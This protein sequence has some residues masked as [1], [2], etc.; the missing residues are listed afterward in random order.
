M[1][2]MVPVM[3][4]SGVVTFVS[5][6]LAMWPVWGLLTPVWILILA[7]GSTFSMMFLPGGRLGNLLFWVGTIVIAYISHT[8]PHDPVW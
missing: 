8:M 4:L 2:Q 3:A 5:S 1:P 7:F 6:I